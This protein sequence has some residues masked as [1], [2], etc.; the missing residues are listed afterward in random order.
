MSE[1]IHPGDQLLDFAYG[2]LPPAASTRVESHLA[3][4]AQC[5][6]ELAS[7]RSVR[8]A[9]APL[10]SEETP[11]EAGLAS[12]LAYA[13]QAAARTRSGPGKAPAGFRRWLAPL[14]SAAVLGLILVAAFGVHGTLQPRSAVLP[15]ESGREPVASSV[16]S[17][18]PAPGSE[19]LRG[20]P[21]YAPPPDPPRVVAER[22]PFEKKPSASK[23][24]LSGFGRTAPKREVEAAPEK[25]AADDKGA[26]KGVGLSQA[27]GSVADA[28]GDGQAPSAPRGAIVRSEHAK[29][30]ATV[31]SSK[32]LASSAPPPDAAASPAA[33]TAPARS[34]AGEDMVAGATLGAGPSGT[35]RAQVTEPT[36]G[37]AFER[38]TRLEAEVARSSGAVRAER[39]N[40]LC[41]LR[42][43]SALTSRTHAACAQLL[44][45]FPESAFAL[46]ARRIL[47]SPEAAEPP[48]EP[49][50]D[51]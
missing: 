12:L 40:V 35:G 43:P 47:A 38:T 46:S 48:A 8:T 39:L 3:T 41:Q 29:K 25:D 16:G 9:M 17:L 51:K 13:E 37:N 5:S 11:P 50:S 10:S 31:E 19:A 42:V 33:M 2:E 22:S 4:C 44:R 23:R 20:A 34:R 21:A 45:E 15:Q 7:I 30:A 24:D 14:M 1:A 6:E 26:S 27:A 49:A 28:A 32:E 36:G 18:R